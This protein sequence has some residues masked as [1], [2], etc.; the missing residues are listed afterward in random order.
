MRKHLFIAGM[1]IAV[2][3]ANQSIAQTN[4]STSSAIHTAVSCSEIGRTILIQGELG[5]PVG[6]EITITGE[7]RANGPFADDFW[8][9]TV[10][11]KAL[12][13]GITVPGIET[14]PDGTKATLRGYE[15]GKLRYLHLDETNFGPHDSRWH[16]PYQ[17]LFMTFRV[18]KVIAPT[19]LR[20]EKR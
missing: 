4:S 15:E 2:A 3:W 6:S 9:E 5:K 14:W 13:K 18:I 1:A 11:G 12:K 16:G 19:G 7:K 8:V 20:I 17:T 10:D